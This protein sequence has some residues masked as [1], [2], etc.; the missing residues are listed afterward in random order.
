MSHLQWLHLFHDR[1][2]ALDGA[3]GDS[4]SN[5]GSG[6]SERLL[7]WADWLVPPQPPPSGT[8]SAA[9]AAAAASPA[10]ATVVVDEEDRE[11]QEGSRTI[12]EPVP[13]RR[14]NDLRGQDADFANGNAAHMDGAVSGGAVPDAGFVPISGSAAS[15]PGAVGAVPGQAVERAD[16]AGTSPRST[17][18]VSSASSS[19]S[20]VMT[21]AGSTSSS[22]STSSSPSPS[23]SSLETTQTADEEGPA[24]GRPTPTTTT[25]GGSPMSPSSLSTSLETAPPD[26]ETPPPLET[27]PS[28]HDRDGGIAVTAHVTRNGDHN[29]EERRQQAKESPSSPAS[30]RVLAAV[31]REFARAEADV[32]KARRTLLEKEFSNPSR[33]HVLQ[34]LLRS[35]SGEGNESVDDG[36]READAFEGSDE[37]GSLGGWSNTRRRGEGAVG[38]PSAFLASVALSLGFGL[39]GGDE[40]DGNTREGNPAV[41]KG[42]EPGVGD[43][44][45][46]DGADGPE[47]GVRDPGTAGAFS[48]S[49]QRRSGRGERGDAALDGDDGDEWFGAANGDREA[50][51]SW[52]FRDSGFC[53]ESD[54]MDGGDPY[55][56]MRGNRS[57][58]NTLFRPL[59]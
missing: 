33:G 44:A 34:V 25:M 10:H 5:G 16:V 51:G 28:V 27:A 53:L 40:C 42:A 8:R 7:K 46:T 32:A 31:L 55:V 14:A 49:S 41:Q 13:L 36:S 48:A 26:A 2:R 45:A 39:G 50:V 23:P 35:L 54:R 57:E 52:G 20:W 3:G 15:H 58:S 6:S 47:A 22:S 4:S 17:T 19:P 11:E 43:D 56:V 30:Q 12:H 9:T 38:T 1:L 59:L 18:Q 21:A 29:A 24:P 37:E